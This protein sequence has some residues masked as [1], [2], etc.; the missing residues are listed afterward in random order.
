MF[1]QNWLLL[2]YDRRTTPTLWVA[3]KIYLQKNNH[4]TVKYWRFFRFTSHSY[5]LNYWRTQVPLIVQSYVVGF[6]PN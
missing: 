6:D 1:Q 3:R 5:R 4:H 2:A